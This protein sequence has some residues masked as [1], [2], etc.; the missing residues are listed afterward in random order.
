MVHSLYLTLFHRIA[1]CLQF[2]GLSFK[3]RTSSSH[4]SQWLPCLFFALAASELRSSN[5]VASVLPLIVPMA[6][7]PSEVPKVIRTQLDLDGDWAMLI[8]AQMEWYDNETPAGPAPRSCSSSSSI[9]LQRSVRLFAICL[10]IALLFFASSRS[11]D[12]RLLR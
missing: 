1:R 11:F 8:R 5:G 10:A 6:M 3:L 4:P 9:Q 12:L 2:F 7:A